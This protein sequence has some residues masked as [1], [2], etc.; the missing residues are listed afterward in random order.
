VSK[1]MSLPVRAHALFCE[2]YRRGTPRSGIEWH[3]SQP[4]IEAAL[5]EADEAGFRRGVAESIEV[6][7]DVVEDGKDSMT[8]VRRLR[9]L[10][11]D[12]HE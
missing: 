5:M 8:T 1:R 9:A 10:L 4:L 6:A 7:K 12:A 11:G 3:S 2:M